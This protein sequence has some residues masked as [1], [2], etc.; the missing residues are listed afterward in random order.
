MT[1]GDV[2]DQAARSAQAEHPSTTAL[3]ARVPLPSAPS[4]QLFALSGGAQIPCP[5]S[6]WP[7][8]LATHRVNKRYFWKLRDKLLDCRFRRLDGLPRRWW[9][10]EWLPYVK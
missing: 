10:R 2:R 7:P 4:A 6:K 9:V 3:G 5:W 1:P 8:G